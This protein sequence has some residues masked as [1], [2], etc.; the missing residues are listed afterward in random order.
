VAPNLN[1]RI[2]EKVWNESAEQ[3]DKMAEFMLGHEKGE[4]NSTVNSLRSI[5]I[6]VLA[7]VGYGKPQKFQPFELPR[8]LDAKMT[9]VE[10][11]SICVELLAFAS[12]LPPRLLRLPIMPKAIRHVGMARRHLPLLTKDM[13]DQERE[14]NQSGSA[15]RENLMSML[16]RLSDQ[17]KSL[18]HG[19]PTGGSGQY[20]TDDEIAGNMFLFT[21]AGFDTTANTLVFAICLLATYPQWQ[22]WIQEEIDLVLGEVK[23]GEPIDYSTCFP[24]LSRCLAL[25][26]RC[27]PASNTMRDQLTRCSWRYFASSHP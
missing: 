2:S 4:S 22:T 20:L 8:E 16:V 1:E 5:A 15:A 13:L 18:D 26:V 11:I 21:G 9:Y 6:N 14:L 19:K 23:D 10:A 24:K 7:Q 25:M 17:E 3:A 27:C 12:L